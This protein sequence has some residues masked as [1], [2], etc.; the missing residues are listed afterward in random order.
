MDK[1][2]T[3]AEYDVLIVGGGAAGLLAGYCAAGRGL[4]TAIL[5]KERRCGRKIL[6]T[7]KGRCNVMNACDVDGFMRRIRSG[8][9][10]LY[11]AR[12]GFGP[13]EARAFFES[14][15]VPLK[16]ERGERMFPESDRAAD[17]ADA[18]VD[19][20]RDAGC[21]FLTGR[22]VA[23]DCAGDGSVCGVHTE[24]GQDIACRAAIV[25][26]GGLSYPKTG[27]TG[28]GYRIA[29][30][31]GHTVVP[32]RA[33]LVPLEC[34]GDECAQLQG[35]ALKNVTLTVKNGKKTL[36][37]EQG[38]M[39]FT[40]FGISGPLVLSASAAT[41]DEQL[42]ALRFMLDLKPALD[43]DMLDKRLLRDFS[44]NI[45]RAFKNA[46]DEL[47]PRKMIPIFI[48][49]SGVPPDQ[50]VNAI[51][52]KQ[53]NKLLDLFKGF[54]LPVSG[55]RPIDEAIVT[56][57]GVKLSEI[58]PKTMQSKIIGNLHFAG[59]LLDADGYTG[60]FNLGIA[61]ATG[62]AAGMHVLEGEKE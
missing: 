41:V 18:L 45:N 23:V 30:Q 42:P 39:L 9:R 49:R 1:Q 11:S 22:A 6:I 34:A 52:Q 4:R 26:T 62:H 44:D 17:I 7:G 55:R 10:F 15:G 59:E 56:A 48:E 27:S 54:A 16:V 24:S 57:G 12:T 14:R 28:D 46:L 5:E 3:P 31:L 19:A 37:E 36:F 8:G 40:H 38:E 43:R 2:R 32:P 47:L 60:G 13:D 51:T 35:L 53:R 33:S 25:A 58:D 20:A 61:F 21:A 50:R 29:K